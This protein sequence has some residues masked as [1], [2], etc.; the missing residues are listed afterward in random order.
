MI[1]CGIKAVQIAVKS[2]LDLYFLWSTMH[3]YWHNNNKK[4]VIIADN[5]RRL[6]MHDIDFMH[7]RFKPRGG[8]TLL[9]GKSLYQDKINT[10]MFLF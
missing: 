9:F 4:H 2:W 3:Q 6:K 1:V 5:N 10:I 8:K 7:F